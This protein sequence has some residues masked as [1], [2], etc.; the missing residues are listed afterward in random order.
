MMTLFIFFNLQPPNK[1]FLKNP[2]FLAFSLFHIN[3]FIKTKIVMNL[4][5]YSFGQVMK[6]I[7]IDSI[8]ILGGYVNA[9]FSNDSRTNSH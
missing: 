5:V 9:K 7:N 6:S 4:W 2:K 3:I 1:I 8:Y